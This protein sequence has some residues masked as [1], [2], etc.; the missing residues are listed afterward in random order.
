MC[1]RSPLFTPLEPRKLLAGSRSLIDVDGDVLSI[2]VIGA[3]DLALTASAGIDIGLI[4]LLTVSNTNASSRLDFKVTSVVGDGRVNLRGL[5]VSSPIRSINAS[6][7]DAM[8]NADINIVDVGQLNWGNVFDNITMFDVSS[9]PSGLNLGSRTVKFGNV[10]SGGAMVFNTRLTAATFGTVEGNALSFLGGVDKLKSSGNLR[11]TFANGA[12]NAAIKEVDVVGALRAAGI[13]TGDVKSIKAGSV[14]STGID[15]FQIGGSLGSFSSKGD[16]AGRFNADYFG[17][18]TAREFSGTL[19]YRLGDT[20]DWGFKSFKLTGDYEGGTVAPASG[21]DPAYIPSFTIPSWSGGILD[22]SGVGSFKVT[23]NL[24]NADIDL[25]G[26]PSGLTLRTF[27]VGGQASGDLRVR[28]NAGAIKL[29]FSTTADPFSIKDGSSTSY[30][31][32]SISLTDKTKDSD[33]AVRVGALLFFSAAGGL[34]DSCFAFDLAEAF[35]MSNF[36]VGGTIVDTEFDAPSTY[37][38]NLFQARGIT[39]SEVDTGYINT[40]TFNKGIG[41]GIN[42]TDFGFSGFNAK[43]YS[44]R[45]GNIGETFENSEFDVTGAGKLG[46]LTSRRYFNSD[47]TATT[48][49]SILATGVPNE[50][51][52][53]MSVWATSNP[54]NGY[55]IKSIDIRGLATNSDIGAAGSIDKIRIN[56]IHALVNSQKFRVSAGNVMTPSSMPG[57]LTGFATGAKINSIDVIN[58]FDANRDDFNSAFFVAPSIGKIKVDGLINFTGVNDGGQ[59]YGFGAAT[60]GQIK[61]K[62]SLGGGLTLIDPPLGANNPFPSEALSNFSVFRYGPL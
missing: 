1:A 49:D 37:G 57:D 4:E 29:G 35:L 7:I 40:L 55:S 34:I 26:L 28:G 21:F 38:V 48:I 22:A 52:G 13:I 27:T 3:G 9:V 10:G 36:K 51:F 43:G 50:A 25:H 24:I 11:T 31:F 44:L 16:F 56:C 41:L 33:L 20:K 19:N 59:P 58:K 15:A 61:L 54:L 17:S 23:G 8:P 18:F 5:N 32:N 53:N 42:N 30:T 62:D 46:S 47:I 60:F 39:D 12:N 45:T 2:S 14:E 6:S